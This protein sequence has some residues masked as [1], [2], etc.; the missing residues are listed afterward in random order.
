[1][2]A[3][4]V[5]LL[6][7]IEKCNAAPLLIMLREQHFRRLNI[8]PRENIL[9]NGIWTQ[10][11]S[12]LQTESPRRRIY[13]RHGHQNAHMAGD[14]QFT[15]S[16]LPISTIS[17]TSNI[18]NLLPLHLPPHRTPSQNPLIRAERPPS[19]NPPHPTP[20]KNP[21]NKPLPFKRQLRISLR[22][23]TSV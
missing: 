14:D 15:C 21:T 2:I 13:S 16:H 11:N 4:F 20:P 6:T 3:P 5:S 10:I 7:E 18:S 17:S 8:G 22:N 12:V 19:T 23:K 1:M 9:N